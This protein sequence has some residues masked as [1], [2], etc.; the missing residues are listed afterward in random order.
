[1]VGS[2]PAAGLSTLR[3]R[4]SGKADHLEPHVYDEDGDEEDAVDVEPSAHF[5]ADQALT[6]LKEQAE[7]LVKKPDP[8]LTALIDELVPLIKK[9]ANPVIFCRYLA[10]AEYVGKALAKK[11]NKATVEVVTGQLTPDARRACVDDMADKPTPRI[12]VATDCLSEGINLQMLFD[13]VIHYDLSW[14]PTRHQQREGRVDRFGQHAKLVRSM[15]MFSPDSAIDGAVL[16]VILRKAAE[17]RKATGVNVPLP[18]ERGP[19]TDAL[20]SSMM[21]RQKSDHQYNF[22]LRT[23]DGKDIMETH[24][25]DVADKEKKSQT[26]FAQ[27]AMKPQEVIPEWDKA[28]ALL[29]SLED[30][31]TFVNRT[32]GHF[33]AA[34]EPKKS[35]FLAHIDALDLPLKERLSQ[36]ELSG[37]IS[38]ATAEPAAEGS[39]LL[40][41]THPLTATLAEALVEASL[42]PESMTALGLGRTGAWKTPAVKSL[43][44]IVL[45]RIRYKLKRSAGNGPQLLLAEEAALVAFDGNGM[46]GDDAEARKLLNTEACADL[47]DPARIR[48]ISEAKKDLPKLLDGPIRE[49]VQ[50]RADVLTQD[51]GRL[52]KTVK[53]ADQKRKET[54]II[55]T[56]VEAV[57]PP[58][59]IGLFVLVPG[60]V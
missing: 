40:S 31:Y 41:R 17:I 4:A 43:T 18:D 24:W 38:L 44:R 57:Q 33:G 5:K 13:T 12:L 39:L 36:R 46:V 23:H 48:F 56:T 2:S 52:A 51:H 54:A 1:C 60:E 47:A 16:E 26:Y 37:S 6:D 32:M 30:V 45:L 7:K 59:V 15:M 3:N 14:N 11:F 58:D 53:S 34:L 10:T 9:K 20:M 21:I 19:V 25:R 55:P 35:T 29:G 8:K 50:K 49:F 27:S 28:K 22:E 42:D